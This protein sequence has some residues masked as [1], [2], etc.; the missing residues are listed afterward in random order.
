MIIH[1]HTIVFNNSDEK[2]ITGQQADEIYRHSCEPA[3]KRIL[4]DGELISFSHIARIKPYEKKLQQEYS[5]LKIDMGKPENLYLSAPLID[6]T[7]NTKQKRHIEQMIKGLKMYING[8]PLSPRNAMPQIT[9]AKTNAP[10]HLLKIMEDKLKS[11]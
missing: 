6:K 10:Y 1:T 8:E 9:G 3:T 5:N 2:H 7:N 11:L 4:I